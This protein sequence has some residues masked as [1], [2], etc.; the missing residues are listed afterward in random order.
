M[1]LISL[2]V[3]LAIAGF[4]TYAILQIPMPQV[5]KNI[6]LGV[7]ALFLVLWVL[8]AFGLTS[9]LNLRLR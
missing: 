7:I 3:V 1:S 8:Q 2:V 4:L 6:I 5:F 9:G